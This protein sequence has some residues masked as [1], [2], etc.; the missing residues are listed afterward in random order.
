[1]VAG[2]HCVTRIK[3]QEGYLQYNT[4]HAST[5]QTEG[6]KLRNMTD[7]IHKITMGQFGFLMSETLSGDR[8]ET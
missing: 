4:L 6:G 5:M 1:M 7:F 8:M 2:H 3:D